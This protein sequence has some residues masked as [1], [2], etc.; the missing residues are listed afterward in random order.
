MRKQ[1]ISVKCF[2]SFSWLFNGAKLLKIVQN[3]TMV[4]QC[5]YFLF[6]VLQK[7]KEEKNSVFSS[8]V[9]QFRAKRSRLSC[10]DQGELLH[11]TRVW[12]F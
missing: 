3:N 4:P 10:L 12:G 1:N 7:H 5:Q 11:A 9:F 2:V 8:E 6:L